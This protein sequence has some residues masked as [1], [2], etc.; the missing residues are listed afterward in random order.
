MRERRRA[1]PSREGERAAFI[2]PPERSLCCCGTEPVAPAE[3]D[4]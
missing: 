2:S 4:G 3:A 1:S